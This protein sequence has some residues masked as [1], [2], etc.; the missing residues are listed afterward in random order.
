MLG[1]NG[2]NIDFDLVDLI[3]TGQVNIDHINIEGGDINISKYPLFD[4]L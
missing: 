3:V 2:V 4:S 1:L